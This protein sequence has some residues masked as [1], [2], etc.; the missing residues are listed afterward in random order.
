MSDFRSTVKNIQRAVGVEADGVFGPSSAAAVMRELNARAGIEE[1][2][3][4]QVISDQWKEGLDDRTI[5]NISTLDAKCREAFVKF[6]LLAKATAATMGVEYVMIS[7]TRTY[8]EQ[9]ALF[10][11]GR[12]A[13]GRI[14]TN[15]KAGDSNHN[16][17][18]AADFGVFTGKA[19]LDSTTPAFA[20]RVH[21]AVAEHAAGCGLEWGGSWSGFTDNPH[22]EVLTGLSM[23]EK[24][25]LMKEKGSVL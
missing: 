14:V 7:G 3:E 8:E 21:I 20:C 18:I 2:A 24:R 6:S 16:F 4:C 9:A 19:Y 11:Q 10:A 13:K 23:A 25:K 12:T 1:S 5:S 22:F 15:A 17:G